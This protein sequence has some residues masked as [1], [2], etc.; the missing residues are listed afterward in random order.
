MWKFCYGAILEQNRG[1]ELHIAHKSNSR[2]SSSS[3]HLC[4]LI[5]ID[6]DIDKNRWRERERGYTHFLQKLY[7]KQ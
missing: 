7:E 1:F 6:I 2:P 5:N 4:V 3:V